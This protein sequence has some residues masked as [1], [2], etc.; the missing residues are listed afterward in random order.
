[1]SL[2]AL[3]ACPELLPVSQEKGTSGRALS[4]VCDWLQFQ[5]RD[6]LQVLLAKDQQASSLP[7][8]N[9]RAAQHT[10]ADMFELLK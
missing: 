1:M 4:P 2:T 5:A 8:P 7:Q 6:T 3:A 10:Q 9:R